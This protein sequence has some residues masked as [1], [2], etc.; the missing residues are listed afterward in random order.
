MPTPAELATQLEALK[1][2]R[3]TGEKRV[4]YNGKTVEYREMSELNDAINTIQAELDAATGSKPS[5]S[6]LAYFGRGFR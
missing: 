1:T 2:A 3:A 5:R 4:T 6:S